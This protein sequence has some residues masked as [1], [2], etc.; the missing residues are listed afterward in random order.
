MKI[1]NNPLERAKSEGYFFL[2]LKISG[3][4]VII[5]L[6]HLPRINSNQMNL[7]FFHAFGRLLV[8]VDFLNLSEGKRS[9]GKNS[10]HLFM[11]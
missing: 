11:C 5:L 8:K 3:S 9:Q 1:H 2:H 6:T 7:N 10:L 4:Y